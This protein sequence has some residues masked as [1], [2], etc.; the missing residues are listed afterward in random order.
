M[1]G[2]LDWTQIVALTSAVTMAVGSLLAFRQRSAKR[3]VAN[4]VVA[5]TGFLLLGLLV[6]D[7]I[8][9]ASI[10]Y[11]LVV[12]LFSLMGVFYVLG[13]LIDE[14]K[15]D[16]LVDLRG[17]LKR[18][19]PECISLILFLL[20]LVGSPPMPGFL[21]KFTLLGA[22]VRHH[23]PGLALVGVISMVLCMAAVVR[24]SFHLIGDIHDTVQSPVRANLSRKTYLGV[25]LF[26]IAFIC[27]FADFIFDWAGQS[28]GFI[29]W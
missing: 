28:L 4:L 12:E 18:A 23:R 3:L 26:P 8:G 25:L 21:G 19:V 11:N 20:C 5:E 14:V 22:A 16:R 10:L 24:L 1:L 7:E 9:I 15:S 6:L 29:F 13:F 17:M 27:V 2:Q